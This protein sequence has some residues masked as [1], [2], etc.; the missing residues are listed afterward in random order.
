MTKKQAI[1]YFAEKFEPF[2]DYWAMQ[3]VW[4]DF[5]D[6]L[7]MDD[8]ITAKQRDTWCNPCTPETFRKFNSRF[9]GGEK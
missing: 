5:V 1:D 3:I 2:S 8:A 4:S 9:N 6:N 7:Y